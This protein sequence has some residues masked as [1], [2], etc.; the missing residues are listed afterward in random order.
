MNT[1]QSLAAAGVISSGVFLGLGTSSV[2]AANFTTT[3]TLNIPGGTPFVDTIA[4]N[5]STDRQSGT[6]LTEDLT[7]WSYELLGNSVSVYSESVI[8]SGVVQSIGGVPRT[9]S[10]IFFRFDLD[11]LTLLSFTN[12]GLI[13]AQGITYDI[14]GGVSGNFAP[15][16]VE[17]Y[18][19][20][21]FVNGG[22][23]FGNRFSQ[24]TVAIPEPT[25]L[26]GLLG[27]SVAGLASRCRRV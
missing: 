18:E 3:L 19:D 22:G 24:S 15:Y 26:V 20:G 7:N 27:V 10:D 9:L 4:I 23:T 17:R 1:I 21:N 16:F 14:Q 6:V 12:A 5:W 8:I 25:V 11:S 13:G 2:L